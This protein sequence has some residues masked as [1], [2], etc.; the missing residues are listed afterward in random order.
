MVDQQGRC[1]LTSFE[2]DGKR[3]YVYRVTRAKTGRFGYEIANAAGRTVAAIS[4]ERWNVA[5]KDKEFLVTPEQYKTHRLYFE[6]LADVFENT[7]KEAKTV[8]DGRLLIWKEKDDVEIL[9][10][11]NDLNTRFPDLDIV[12]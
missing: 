6:A 7:G 11:F 10:D 9:F 1:T 12:D 5:L 4:I 8:R 2:I 3:L